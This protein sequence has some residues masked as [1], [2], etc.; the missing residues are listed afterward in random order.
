MTSITDFVMAAFLVLWSARWRDSEHRLAQVR[1]D[2]DLRPIGR[3][4]GAGQ[5]PS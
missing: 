1:L 5:N 3:S 4:G 2:G